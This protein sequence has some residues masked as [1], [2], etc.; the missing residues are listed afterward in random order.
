M[1][2]SKTPSKIW[3]KCFL[4]V[5]SSEPGPEDCLESL[6]LVNNS[7]LYVPNGTVCFEC[8]Y[9]NLSIFSNDVLFRINGKV[10]NNSSESARVLKNNS[11][12]T[13]TVVVF[14][15]AEWFEHF[16]V[17]YVQC[18]EAGHHVSNVCKG[19]FTQTGVFLIGRL[20]ITLL[21]PVIYNNASPLAFNPPLTTGETTVVEGSTLNLFCNGSNSTPQPTLQWISP[22]GKVVGESGELT[23]VTVTRN[24]AGTYT[25]VATLPGS[26][27]TMNTSV[28]IT[29]IPS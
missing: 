16:S 5:F 24:M 15:T 28:D 25:C 21:Y 17:T 9:K 20:I 12:F 3:C 19:V 10:I 26:T 11:I 18:C 8:N 7:I 4:T 1:V 22:N 2:G 13:D 29:I 23:I 27:A 6:T 14:D